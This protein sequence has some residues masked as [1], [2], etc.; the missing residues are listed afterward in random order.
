MR[1]YNTMFQKALNSN[2]LP[3]DAAAVLDEM[4]ERFKSSHTDSALK[5][6]FL[7]GIDTEFTYLKLLEK[8]VVGT[9]LLYLLIFCCQYV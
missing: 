7:L 4:I 8:V 5:S 2:R 6:L 3:H 9:R 1:M